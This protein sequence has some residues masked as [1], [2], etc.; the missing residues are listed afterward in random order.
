MFDSDILR[1]VRSVLATLHRKITLLTNADGSTKRGRKMIE[2]LDRIASCNDN[3]TLR[4]QTGNDVTEKEEDEISVRIIGDDGQSPI[5]FRTLPEGNFL[6]PFL[7]AILNV[8]GTGF[9]LSKD[10]LKVAEEIDHPITMVTY[11]GEHSPWTPRAL[12]IL[13]EIVA[14]NPLLNNRVEDARSSAEIM[15]RYGITNTPAV[16]INDSL[17]SEGWQSPRDIVDSLIKIPA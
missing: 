5:E 1:G 3:L 2:A 11:V 10:V 7:R 8:G 16:T 15:H 13:N 14:V 9:T 4:L 6:S 17:I 12:Q